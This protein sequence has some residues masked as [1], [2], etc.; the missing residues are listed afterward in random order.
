M[1]SKEK[2]KEKENDAREMAKILQ[3]TQA[4]DKKAIE[5]IM[6]ALQLGIEI[7]KASA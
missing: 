6:I 1:L 3:I 4:K 7:G 5:A 2:L